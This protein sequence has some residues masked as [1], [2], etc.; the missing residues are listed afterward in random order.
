MFEW[1][2]YKEMFYSTGDKANQLGST[3]TDVA[4]SG[5]ELAKKIKV[6]WVYTR[7]LII[8]IVQVTAVIVL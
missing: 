5:K 1:C 4:D 8:D 2:Y 6:I 7:F 3:V